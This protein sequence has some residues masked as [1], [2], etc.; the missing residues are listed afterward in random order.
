MAATA[1]DVSTQPGAFWKRGHHRGDLTGR[2]LRGPR[3]DGVRAHRPFGRCDRPK[4]DP[5]F[6]LHRRQVARR[7]QSGEG[8]CPGGCR[9]STGRHRSAPWIARVRS[10]RPLVVATSEN[11]TP[12]F[13]LHRRDVADRDRRDEAGSVPVG[14]QATH[15]SPSRASSPRHKSACR[16]RLGRPDPGESGKPEQAGAAYPSPVANRW[17]AARAAL[18]CRRILERPGVRPA[19][20]DLLNLPWLK[21][22]AEREPNLGDA[23]NWVR[24]AR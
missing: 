23:L 2:R 17:N 14:Q 11:V 3:A 24:G 7:D 19:T 13:S 12:T 9:G 5:N 22:P 10:H 1:R 20:R 6:S 15:G 4:S 16:R 21:R 8:E 18:E